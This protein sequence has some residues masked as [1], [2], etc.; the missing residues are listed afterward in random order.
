ETIVNDDL[1]LIV[2]LSREHGRQALRT[3]GDEIYKLLLSNADSF[4]AEPANLLTGATSALSFD[5][6]SA[7]VK[8]F[9]SRTDS[10]GSPVDVEPA[11]LLV[12]PALEMSAKALIKSVT[13]TLD[14]ETAVPTGNPLLE[15]VTVEVEPR[16]ASTSIHADAS[17]HAWYLLAAAGT[18]PAM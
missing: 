16:L 13:L 7:A 3:V 6:V 5:S 2:E 8:L 11:V 15:M 14:S 1:G 9:R 17:D 18:I 10:D 12:P 4:F